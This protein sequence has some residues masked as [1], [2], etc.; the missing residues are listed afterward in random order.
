MKITDTIWFTGMYGNMGIVLGEDTITG[1]RKAYIGTH[2]GVGEESDRQLIAEGG[3]RLS[4]G[5]VE[6]I[7]K[8]FDAE[9][10]S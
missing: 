8:H 4:R 1:E 6:R 3:A 7:L 5:I 2:R 9:E 10:V